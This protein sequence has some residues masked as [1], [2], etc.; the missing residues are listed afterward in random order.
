MCI[1]VYG[2]NPNVYDI[3]YNYYKIKFK[4]KMNKK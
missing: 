4:F 3:E 2:T 1:Y